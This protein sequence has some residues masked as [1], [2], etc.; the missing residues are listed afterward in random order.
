MLLAHDETRKYIWMCL[1]A[2]GVI[3]PADDALRIAS[4]LAVKRT[5]IHRNRIKELKVIQ[6]ISPVVPAVAEVPAATAKPKKHSRPVPAKSPFEQA[7]ALRDTLHAA[8]KLANELA[9]EF[10]HQRR[11]ARIVES[12]LSSLRQFKGRG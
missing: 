2:E 11:Q 3:P 12:T 1:D 7:I 8:A 10:K 4:P 6:P 5:S 9:R